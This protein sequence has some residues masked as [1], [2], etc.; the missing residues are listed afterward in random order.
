MLIHIEVTLAAHIQVHHAVVG[1]LLQ[2][3]VKETEARMYVA[4]TIAVQIETHLDVGLAGRSLDSGSAL[5][6]KHH[7]AH[8]VPGAGLAELHTLCAQIVG[9][10]EVS[11]PVAYHPTAGQV[12]IALQIGC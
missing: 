7:L 5:P 3:V 10:H 6:G 1:Q 12:V 8:L 11:I 4:L 9:Q 2:H